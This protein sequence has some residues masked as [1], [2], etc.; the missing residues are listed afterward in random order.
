MVYSINNNIPPS[1]IDGIPIINP[2]RVRHSIMPRIIN[3]KPIAFLT[4]LQKS[5]N[6][7]IIIENKIII[8]IIIQFLK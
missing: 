6:K 4:G 3:S 5:P 2:I 7:K 8:S 1:N